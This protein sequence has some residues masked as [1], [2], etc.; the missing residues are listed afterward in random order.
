ML[1]R[2]EIEQY[3][4]LINECLNQNERVVIEHRQKRYYLHALDQWTIT[5][6]ER[7]AVYSNSKEN[8][9]QHQLLEPGQISL[10][11]LDLERNFSIIHPQLEEI[12]KTKVKLIELAPSY[13]GSIEMF[14]IEEGMPSPSDRT[15][16]MF[17]FVQDHYEYIS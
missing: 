14:I 8:F 16:K 17:R 9:F 11:V 6:V 5:L 15:G 1:T 7:S 4:N 10:L 2:L 12:V 13:D 3:N